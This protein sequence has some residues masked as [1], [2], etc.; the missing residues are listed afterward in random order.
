[1][2]CYICNRDLSGWPILTP[3]GLQ[4]ILCR[5]VTIT[6]S[7]TDDELNITVS[8]VK[9]VYNRL[10]SQSVCDQ[11]FQAVTS[12]SIPEIVP[13]S[14]NDAGEMILRYFVTGSCR[15]CPEPLLFEDSIN[16]DAFPSRALLDTA[17]PSIPFL[18]EERDLQTSSS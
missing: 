4:Y 18:N 3:R 16:H 13:D 17:S 1:M 11:L 15:G 8:A 6:D 5:V 9:N 2:C 7:L 10:M 14:G 12:V